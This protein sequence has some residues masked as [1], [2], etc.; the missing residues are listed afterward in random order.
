[1]ILLTLHVIPILRE[2]MTVDERDPNANIGLEP[3]TA[4]MVPIDDNCAICPSHDIFNWHLQS[5]S[6]MDKQ[7]GKQKSS[8]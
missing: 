7:L 6:K 5:G 4:T 2:N 8:T 3:A 1:M